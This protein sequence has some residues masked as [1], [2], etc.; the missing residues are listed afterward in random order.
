MKNKNVNNY[1]IKNYKR[2][3]VQPSTNVCKLNYYDK[4]KAWCQNNITVKLYNMNYQRVDVMIGDLINS[5][6]S[7]S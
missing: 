5:H 7:I 4:S 1:S 6:P 3:Y 2:H